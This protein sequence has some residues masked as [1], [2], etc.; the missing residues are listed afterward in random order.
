MDN[1]TEI[2][3]AP[4]EPSGD[5]AA[6]AF[7]SLREEVALVRRAIAGLAAERAANQTPDYS[8]ALGQIMR[9]TQV[10]AAHLKALAAMPALRLTANN[11]SQEIAA[12][13]E[14]V[15]QTDHHMLTRAIEAFQIG[16]RDIGD[17]LHS[18]RDGERQNMW[19]LVTG[20]G[21]VL[22]GMFLWG[23]LAGPVLRAVPESWH[24]PERLAANIIGLDAENAGER[25][26]QSSAPDMWRDIV[27]GYRLMDQNREAIAQCEKAKGSA[28]AKKPV[29]C[30]LRM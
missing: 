17:R 20:L 12:A 23:V 25:L 19:L 3:N 14:N 24:W 28:R 26:I 15:R 13:G 10:V 22:V 5:P 7:E 4:Q 11:W 30:E 18:A 16:A 8:E 21:G 27:R 1:Q 29:R 9:A 6:V 2:V